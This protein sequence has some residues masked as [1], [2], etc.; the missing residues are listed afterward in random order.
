MAKKSNSNILALLLV[1]GL[2]TIVFVSMLTLED[3]NSI[4]EEV[5]PDNEEEDVTKVAPAQKK[6]EKQQRA[7]K[8]IKAALDEEL[9]TEKTTT[10]DVDIKTTVNATGTQKDEVKVLVD[11]KF[12]TGTQKTTGYN[13]DGRGNAV[14]LD[15]HS[16]DCGSN[17]IS[18]FKLY[19]NANNLSQFQYGYTC[20]T[21]G[22]K[23]GPY[24]AKNT[25]FNDDGGGNV[26]Y[27]DRHNV[28]CGSDGVLSQFNLVRNNTS[29]YRY[30]Y[31][32]LPSTKPLTCRNAS[33]VGNEDGKGNAV[34]LDRH[35]V[36]CNEDE[37]LNQFK[38][39]RPKEDQINYEYKCCK[40]SRKE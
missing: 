6:R 29:Q 19:R 9:K 38:L 34:Y 40:E 13:D 22:P 14:Y 17:G 39:Y 4:E 28:D 7:K 24:M 27:L 26:V 23:L 37:V 33:T 35:D 1:I 12:K 18:Q 3:T 15:R 2:L 5:T 8:S 36:K 25:G 31:K 20:S 16:L 30:E 32:C 21:G 11:E 10:N